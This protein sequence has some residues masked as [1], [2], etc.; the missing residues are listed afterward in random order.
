MSFTK[1]EWHFGPRI[2]SNW[3]W[4]LNCFDSVFAYEQRSKHRITKHRINQFE[5]KMLNS[6]WSTVESCLHPLDSILKFMLVEI[7]WNYHY[8]ECDKFSTKKIILGIIAINK[9]E[10]NRFVCTRTTIEWLPDWLILMESSLIRSNKTNTFSSDFESHS[11]RIQASI[12]R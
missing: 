6:L 7:K 2:K 5:Q 8:F 9:I 10:P 12:F 11:T 1:N 3:W 4:T